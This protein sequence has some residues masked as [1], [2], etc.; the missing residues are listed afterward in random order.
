MTQNGAHASKLVVAGVD[1]RVRRDFDLICRIEEAFGEIGAFIMRS[2][3]ERLL[4][5]DLARL[6]GILLDGEVQDG[7]IREHILAVGTLAAFRPAIIICGSLFLG[8]ERFMASLQR[9]AE[10]NPA[11]LQAGA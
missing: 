7:A 9:Q 8:E 11:A 10:G 5:A 1:Y 6:Y 4:A 3:S 2:E